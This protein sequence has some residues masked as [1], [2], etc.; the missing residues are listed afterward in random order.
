M[1]GKSDMV[2]QKVLRAPTPDWGKPR[3]ALTKRRHELV[4]PHPLRHATVLET[5]ET[6]WNQ[7]Y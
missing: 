1:M 6:L 5:A 3:P 4:L 7:P 2:R